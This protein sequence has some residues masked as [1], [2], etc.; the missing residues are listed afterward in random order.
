LQGYSD[1]LK[2][3][4][5]PRSGTTYLKQLIELNFDAL[6]L[7]DALGFQHGQVI[8]EIDWTGHD[9]PNPDYWSENRIE[10]LKKQVMPFKDD[11]QERFN[12]G[13]LYFVFIIKNPYAWYHSIRLSSRDPFEPLCLK[14]IYHWNERN[15]HYFEY[16]GE[17]ILSC[18]FLR[19][20]QFYNNRYEAILDYI[21]MWFRLTKRNETFQNIKQVVSQKTVESDIGE[22]NM[23]K[24]EDKFYL[25]KL[26]PKVVEGI[27]KHVDPKLMEVCDYEYE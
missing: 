8:R 2:V 11:I 17:H 19:Y 22:F 18:L 1:I 13:K 27:T 23:K 9:W 10:Q 7:E 5:L 25:D 21:R 15:R 4:G 26:G 16:C 3:Y 14:N 12:N 20:E 24:Y 6:V